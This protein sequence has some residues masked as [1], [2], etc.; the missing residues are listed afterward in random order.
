MGEP[1]VVAD[2]QD[3]PVRIVAPPVRCKRNPKLMRCFVCGTGKTVKWRK[4]YL[5]TGVFWWGRCVV[6]VP[7][8]SLLL[9]LAP[10]P[11]PARVSLF[12]GRAAGCATRVDF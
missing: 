8:R 7:A 6:G 3:P 4:L 10:S 11:P 12:C 2:V 9:W 5:E 1:A